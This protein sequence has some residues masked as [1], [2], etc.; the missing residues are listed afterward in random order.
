MTKND[1]TGAIRRYALDG[2]GFVEEVRDQGMDFEV[3]YAQATPSVA[4]FLLPVD[5]DVG[6]S[7]PPSTPCLPAHHH[8]SHHDDKP[9]TL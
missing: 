8:T 9:L 2:V 4:V 5:P 6:V 3:S 7:T 1:P